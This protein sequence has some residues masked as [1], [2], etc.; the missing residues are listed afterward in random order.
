MLILKTESTLLCRLFSKQGTAIR[1]RKVAKKKRLLTVLCV[2]LVRHP[3][4]RTKIL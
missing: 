4:V 1:L 2:Y 3:K